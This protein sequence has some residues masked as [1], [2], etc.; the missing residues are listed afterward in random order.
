MSVLI[1]PAR[2]DAQMARPEDVVK[3]TPAL[4][5]TGFNAGE[6]FQAALILDIME[7]YHLNAHTVRDPAMIPTDLEVPEDSPIK[8]QFVRYPEDQTRE[9]VPVPGYHD[10]QYHE[11]V[12]I[13]LVGRLPADAELGKLKVRVIVRYQTCTDTVCL[14]PY[15]KA[16]DLEI[17]IVAPGTK[18]EEVNKEIFGTP[19][20]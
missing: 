7:G 10:E 20:G 8:F 13:R 16:A 6:V 9:G 19:G 1:Q 12:M 5:K 11:R 2:A 3:I 14:Y 18:V 15:G 4:P 17:P